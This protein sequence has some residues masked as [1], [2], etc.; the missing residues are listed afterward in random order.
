MRRAWAIVAALGVA[1]WPAAGLARVEDPLG[2][3]GEGVAPAVEE[4][5][6][7]M[8]A[9][10]IDVVV[11]AR[12]P[13]GAMAAAE[14][15]LAARPRAVAVV[16]HAARDGETGLAVAPS[17]RAAGLG[18]ERAARLV[19]A[20][21]P[22]AVA[23][24][25]P[26]EGLIALVQEVKLVEATATPAGHAPPPPPPRW[27]LLATLGGGVAGAVG[28][29]AWGVGRARRRRLAAVRLR[30]TA[31]R[32]RL[33]KL[34]EDLAGLAAAL[35]AAPEASRAEAEQAFAALEADQAALRA[36]LRGLDARLA[37]PMVAEV[38]GGLA[39]AARRVERL[40]LGLAALTA[41]AAT[42]Q[43]AQAA[44]LVARWAALAEVL[45]EEAEPVVRLARLV[46][47]PAPDMAAFA[48]LLTALERLHLARLAR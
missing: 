23:Q 5:L 17:L 48:E 46:R 37:L 36:E 11:V 4:Q 19:A 14:A 27:P 25:V 6:G 43:A 42:G 22:P 41:A 8:N 47:G 34:R 30:L 45:G 10:A 9:G 20:A 24:G 21:M 15:A 38:A 31:E 2:L 18:P 33:A 35:G 39:A 40:E 12:A 7:R 29:A 16:L 28:L 1:L 44:P 26:S 32:G 13:E 3:L